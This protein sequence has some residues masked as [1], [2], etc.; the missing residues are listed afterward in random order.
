[1]IGLFRYID[2]QDG[3]LMARA[4]V[5]ACRTQGWASPL[6]P[7]YLRA[8]FS[9]V[10]GQEIDFETLEPCSIDDAREVFVTPEQL[11]EVIELMLG[12]EL[13]VQPISVIQSES[14]E[15]WAEA[16]GVKSHSL[17]T[18][19]AT[20]MGAHR[21]AQAD[22]YRHGYW[23]DLAKGDPRFDQLL[24]QYGTKAYAV[25]VEADPAEVARWQALEKCAS[26][27]LG[28]AVWELYTFYGF[29]FPGV[30][31]S[32]NVLTALHD[33]IHVLVDYPPTGLGE[34][35]LG[36]FRMASSKLP[37]ANISF[38]AELGFW[39]SGTIESVLTGWH[40]DAFSL[41]VPGGA[42]RVADA[43]RRGQAC[44]RDFYIDCDFFDF[45]DVPVDEI[46]AAWNIVP[47]GVSDS[48]GWRDGK[49]N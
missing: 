22:L 40:R 41:E 15:S 43:M 8:I 23:G 33:W 18:V 4:I 1:M 29:G 35:E 3:A 11:A 25:T 34:I 17:R 21:I 31:G 27:S 13:L 14:I 2:P 44:K 6:Q 19:R 32:A 45:K 42:E 26:D 24:Q 36:A 7:R 28:R 46:R 16:L 20:A 37:G 5:G 30:V 48:P 47:K 49:T 12:V 10:L 38:L 9:A 39:Q